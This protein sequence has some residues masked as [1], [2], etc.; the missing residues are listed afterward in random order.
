MKLKTTLRTFAAAVAMGAAVMAVSAETL[1]TTL[2][3]HL[4]NGNSEQF[5]LPDKPVITFGDENMEVKSQTMEASYLRA[6][7]DY[8]NFD[9]LTNLEDG[10]ID[11]SIAMAVDFIDNNTLVVTAPRLSRVDVVAV[12]GAVV[13]SAKAA[14]GVATLNLS[15]LAAGVY[16]VV[17]AECRAF[18]IV[19]K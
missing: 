17:P 6:D 19:K 16:V 1:V 5:S 13:A 18:K 14:G 4:K 11:S 8:F 9:K 12:N 10:A 7:V 2:T 3:V 15:K